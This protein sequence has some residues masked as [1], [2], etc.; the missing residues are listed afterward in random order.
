MLLKVRSWNSSQKDKV[1]NTLFHPHT[2]YLGVLDSLRVLLLLYNFGDH[3]YANTQHF[4]S[5]QIRILS[6]SNDI[7]L[8]NVK[9]TYRLMLENFPNIIYNIIHVPHTKY[10]LDNQISNKYFSLAEENV[11]PQVYMRYTCTT[12]TVKRITW[13]DEVKQGISVLIHLH[14]NVLLKLQNMN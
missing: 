4:E 5:T 3:W 1:K 14:I 12:I 7:Q 11:W 2:S 9:T 13:I 8:I 6:K 10:S